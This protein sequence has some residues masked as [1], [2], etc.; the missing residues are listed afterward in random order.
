[1]PDDK[2]GEAIKVF[3]IKSDPT[4][5]EEDRR[6]LLP[7]ESHRLQAAEVHRVPRRAAQEQCRQD[8]AARASLGK[9]SI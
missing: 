7:G 5:T 4:L 9:M 8:P 6:P 2:Q 3:V 1:L